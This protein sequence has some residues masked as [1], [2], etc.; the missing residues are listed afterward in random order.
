MKT[1]R[2]KTNAK[3]GGCV[4]RI[5][6]FLDRILKEDEWSFDLASPDKVL[7]V[8]SEKPDELIMDAV[9]EAGYKIEKID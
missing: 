7:N 2:F 3:C 4:A 9:R 5:K 6:P 1:S 8:T